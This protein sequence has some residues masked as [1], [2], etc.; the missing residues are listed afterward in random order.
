MN[1]A[2]IIDELVISTSRSGGKG[3]QHVNKTESK[4]D[5]L[6]DIDNSNGLDEEEKALIKTR[7]SSQINDGKIHVI[8][9]FSRSQIQNREDAIEK[10]IS[11]LTK[12]TIKPKKRKPTKPSKSAKLKIRKSK[13]MRKEIKA[14]RKKPY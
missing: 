3:G 2:T 8:S 1:V 7:F 13:E 4:V 9:Q 12:G 14:S 10:L 5:V 6:F 11:L